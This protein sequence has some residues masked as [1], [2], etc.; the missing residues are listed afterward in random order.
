VV[1]HF[2]LVHVRYA[3]AWYACVCSGLCVCVYEHVYVCCVHVCLCVCS[4]VHMCV[5]VCVCRCAYGGQRL[6]LDVVLHHIFEIRLLLNWN[7]LI[8]RGCVC[9]WTSGICLSVSN[10]GVTVP[11][12]CVNARNP[13]SGPH[14]CMASTINWTMWVSPLL[15]VVSHT[16]L[17]ILTVSKP[18]WDCSQ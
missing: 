14:A 11:G 4:S 6:A 3:L 17:W 15:W 1:L 10:T 2:I 9:Q 8:W 12:L 5:Y 16:V 7:A 18:P 13:S